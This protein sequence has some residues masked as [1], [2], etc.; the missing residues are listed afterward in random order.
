MGGKS[1]HFSDFFENVSHVINLS[2]AA[3]MFYSLRYKSFFLKLCN[4]ARGIQK[5]LSEVRMC[6]LQVWDFRL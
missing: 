2:Y 1:A 6:Y 4:L 3:V 5:N